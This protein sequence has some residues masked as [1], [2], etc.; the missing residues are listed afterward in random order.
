[1]NITK[2]T[3]QWTTTQIAEYINLTD[4]IILVKMTIK[5]NDEIIKINYFPAHIDDIDNFTW[6]NYN[7]N[8]MRGKFLDFAIMRKEFI[9]SYRKF[10]PDFYEFCEEY[11]IENRDAYEGLITGKITL[12]DI[13]LVEICSFD[14]TIYPFFYGVSKTG[15]I[16]HMMPYNWGCYMLTN[17][18]YDLNAVKDFLIPLE[19]HGEV[20]ICRDDIHDEIIQKI[21][22]YNITGK[23]NKYINFFVLARK[24]YECDFGTVGI[25]EYVDEIEKFRI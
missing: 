15:W 12:D 4:K 8:N 17:G 21:P 7:P 6:A 1:M 22:S 9:E 14:D 25:G 18:E 2:T 3:T 23:A 16:P 5:C 11:T 20:Y 13:Q 24:K 10:V 19:M